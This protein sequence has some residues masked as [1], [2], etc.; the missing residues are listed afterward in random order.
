VATATPALAARIFEIEQQNDT[1]VVVPVVNLRELEYRRIEAG[2]KEILELLDGTGIKNVVLDFG[3]TDYYGSTALG[4][5]LKLWK[6][7]RRRNGCM[8]FCNVS[9]HEQEILQVTNLDHLWPICPSRGEALEAV[10]ENERLSALL[11]LLVGGPFD[12][13]PSVRE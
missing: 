6:R 12:G 10:Q 3:K 11:R 5:F 9:D 7:V 8:A 4:F 13:V 1:I 2:A